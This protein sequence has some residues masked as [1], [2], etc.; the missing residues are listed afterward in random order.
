MLRLI[1]EQTVLGPILIDDIDDGLPNKAA[2]RMGF[3]GDPHHAPRDGYA[4][5]PKQPSYIPR[6]KAGEET[7]AG[8]IDLD[9]TQ[10]VLLS[11][12][13]GKIA[14]HQALGTIRVVSLVASDLTQP[15][16]S[17]ATLGSPAS[18]DVTIA[19]TGFLSVD[20]DITTVIFAGAGVGSVTLTTA[21][22]EAVSPG[23]VGNTSIVVDST[24]ISGLTSGDTIQVR[25][26]G[27]LSNVY[28]LP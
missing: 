1:H 23:S 24:L 4:N 6:V 27:Q 5:E 20:P 16:I 14:G 26:D 8:Y 18:G 9:E 10:R 12:S 28:T 7:V 19:G 21:Q 25:A 2:H 17:G 15:N 22:I 3:S 13:N 11:A